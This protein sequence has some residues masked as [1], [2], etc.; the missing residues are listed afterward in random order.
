MSCLLGLA[1]VLFSGLLLANLGIGW[2]VSHGGVS[3]TFHINVSFVT[4][5][6]VLFSQAMVLFYLLGSVRRVRQVTREKKLD[7]ALSKNLPA[8]RAFLPV[9]CFAILA[10][11]AAF[12][13]GGGAHTGVVSAALHGWLSL[14]AAALQ[15]WSLM[16]QIAALR[17]LERTIQSIE[18]LLDE[19]H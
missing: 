12:I 5:I 18:P 9:A 8:A 3:S 13:L 14:D 15:T 11:M 17:T 2:F 4:T 1:A 19:E 6:G 7:P 10:V 16:Q